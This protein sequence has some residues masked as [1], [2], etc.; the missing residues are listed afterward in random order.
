[1]ES[2]PESTPELFGTFPDLILCLARL[3]VFIDAGRFYFVNTCCF[4]PKSAFVVKNKIKIK[5]L[6]FTF[7]FVFLEVKH[8]PLEKQLL[9]GVDLRLELFFF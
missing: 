9:V 3:D 7:T 5:A 6:G 8:F 4:Y 1:M 2:D